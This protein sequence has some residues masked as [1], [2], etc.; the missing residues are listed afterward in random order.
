MRIAE[1]VMGIVLALLSLYIMWKSGERPSWS[2]EARFSN[3]W[4]GENGAPDGGFWPFWV[5]A[6]MLACCVWVVTNG[7][8]KLSRPG[9]STE[10]YLDAHG[11]GVLL[12]VGFP[13]FLLVLLTDVISIY[14]A[15]AL[16]LFYYVLVLGRH[17]WLLAGAL[18]LILPFWL[19]LFFDIAMTRNLPKGMRAIEDVF[20]VPAG[21][22]FRSISG[23]ELGLFF[24]A[25]GVLLALAAIVS[26]RRRSVT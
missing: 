10:P 22:W 17:G 6:I 23:M 2:G 25:G 24:V 16:F 20:Y 12:R 26:A 18:A 21:N 3:I 9:K 5:C 8:L 19:Y 1:I 4:F 11:I 13:V 14:F 7:V 15:M